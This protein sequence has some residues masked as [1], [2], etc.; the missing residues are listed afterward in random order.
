MLSLDLKGPDA[1]SMPLIPQSQHYR[2]RNVIPHSKLVFSG[3][4][5]E[6]RYNLYPVGVVASFAHS[7]KNNMSQ[8]KGF[9]TFLLA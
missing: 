7:G 8:I 9:D 4:Q 6:K 1:F 3:K 5:K 2:A